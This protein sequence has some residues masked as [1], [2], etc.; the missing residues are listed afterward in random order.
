MRCR[1]CFSCTPDA[2]VP[3]QTLLDNYGE[4]YFSQSDGEITKSSLLAGDYWAKVR[5][6]PDIVRRQ[7]T[8]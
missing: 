5:K 8:L 1:A 3:E 6:H 2:A 7:P 4:N